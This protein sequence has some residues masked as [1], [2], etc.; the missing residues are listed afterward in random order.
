MKQEV[1][2]AA[3]LQLLSTAQIESKECYGSAEEYLTLNPP[4]GAGLHSPWE[5]QSA[6]PV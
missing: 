4:Q 6:S 1:R 2:D 5:T 3:D